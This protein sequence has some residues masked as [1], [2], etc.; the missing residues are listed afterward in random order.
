MS[1]YKRVVQ[2][3]ALQLKYDALARTQKIDS[4]LM[5]PVWGLVLFLLIMTALFTSIF[6]VAAPL[7]DWVDAIFTWA[8]TVVQ[9]VAP[10][11]L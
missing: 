7:M 6:W 11:Q 5:H 1:L 10:N 2:K 3:S 8:G 9:K 4:V